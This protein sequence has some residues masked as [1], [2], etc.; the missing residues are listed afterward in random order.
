[1]KKNILLLNQQDKIPNYLAV[2]RMA[3]KILLKIDEMHFLS[4]KRI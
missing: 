4:I 2:R 3:K 1:M